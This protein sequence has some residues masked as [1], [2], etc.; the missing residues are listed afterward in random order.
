LAKKQNIAIEDLQE[1]S[2]ILREAGSGTQ[3]IFESVAHKKLGAVNVKLELGNSEA[4][5]QAVKSGIALGCLSKLAIAAEV[6]HGDLT[7]IT[8]KELN[9][10]REFSMIQSKT[11][12]ESQVLEH[13]KSAVIAAH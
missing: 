8:V 6:A 4:I 9:F 5:K 3:E 10:E 11:A 7:V 2:W 1:E 12:F 13:F